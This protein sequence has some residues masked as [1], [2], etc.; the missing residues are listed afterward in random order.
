MSKPELTKVPLWV[1]IFNVPLE[2]W[3]VEGINQIASRVGNPIIM[4]RITTA[5]CEKSHG[6]ASFARV[7][8][9]VNYVKGLVDEIESCQSKNLS[10][11][12]KRI[13]ESMK[14]VN[15]LVVD[16]DRNEGWRTMNY[17]RGDIVEVSVKV[18]GDRLVVAEEDKKDLGKRGNNVVN[19]VDSVNKNGYVQGLSSKNRFSMLNDDEGSEESI[20]WREFY[21]RIDVA[22]EIGITIDEA[23]KLTCSE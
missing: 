21:M 15:V 2:A 8:V 4:D 18:V 23:E 13:K 1:K 10:E 9:E 19:E 22:C 3:N 16:S 6:R 5:M 20:E 17:R 7:L 14:P 12:E 11:E